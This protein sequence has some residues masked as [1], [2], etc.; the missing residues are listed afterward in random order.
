MDRGLVFTECYSAGIHTY[1]GIYSTL[2][3]HPALLARHPMKQ[4][5]LPE[6]CGLPQQ[7]RDMGY[8]NAFFMTHDENYD[9]MQGFLRANG[10]DEIFGQSRFPSEESVGTWGVPD[11]VLFDHV[12]AH[13]NDRAAT[14]PFFIAVMTCSN[15]S[16][17]IIPEGITF[18]PHSKELSKQVV[19]YADWSIGHFMREASRQPWFHNTLFVF[20]ADHGAARPSVYDVSLSYHH[21]PL[22]FYHPEM[23]SPCRIDRLALQLDVTSTVLG[24]MPYETTQQAFGLDLL[25]QRR[26]YAYFSDDDKL[27]VLDGEYLYLRRMAEKKESLYHYP[28]TLAEDFIGRYPERADSMRDYAY[29]M[30]QHSFQMISSGHASCD[31]DGERQ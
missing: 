7:L 1:N 8:H 26:S 31:H 30:I 10:F 21:I 4:T 24:M 2:Y 19:E 20:I 25:R 3:S 22:L 29:G 14:S 12:V 28:D 9:N 23:I 15:H 5:P 13:C 6:M 16:P 18:R 11:H 17:F 27:G